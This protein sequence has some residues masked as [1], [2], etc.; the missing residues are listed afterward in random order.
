MLSYTIHFSFPVAIWCKKGRTLCLDNKELY[1]FLRSSL[2]YCDSSC[3]I[4]ITISFVLPMR[5]KCTCAVNQM[6]LGLQ[7]FL[8][9]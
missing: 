9:Y 2:L 6:N 5:S 3:V 8:D 1:V 7:F 4:Q